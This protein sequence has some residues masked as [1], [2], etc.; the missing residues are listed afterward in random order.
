MRAFALIGALLLPSSLKAAEPPFF[1]TWPSELQ[2]EIVRLTR[3]GR[4]RQLALYVKDLRTGTRYTYNAATPTYLASGIKVPVLVA[5]F[6]E[7]AAGRISLE[8]EMTYT[9]LDIRDGAPL[10]SYLKFGTPISLRLLA[11]AMIQQSDNAATDMIIKRIGLSRVNRAMAREKLSGFGPITSLLEV[12]QIVLSKIEPRVRSLTPLQYYRVGV[13]RPWSARL[14]L[15]SELLELGPGAITVKMYQRAYREYYRAGY[16]SAPLESMGALMEGL[17]RGRVVSKAMSREM[18]D[19][20]LGT[21]TGTARFRAGLPPSVALAHKTGTQFQRTCD[22]AVFYL[23]PDHPVVLVGCVKGGTRR[24]AERMLA[25]AARYAY[26]SLLPP[27][28]RIRV[29]KIIPEEDTE[30]DLTEE[31]LLSPGRR[32]SRR[33]KRLR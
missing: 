29:P 15:L 5:L 26:W 33:S 4:Q 8:E 21:Q 14:L 32:R 30:D 20:L 7:V 19:I 2:T 13:T 16:N 10:L 28:E 12:R 17:A 18:M 27:R 24:R 3:R 6:Q 23:R 22:F 11:E 1:P 31:E 25:Q 9:E